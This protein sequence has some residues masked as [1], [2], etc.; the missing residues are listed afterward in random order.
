MYVYDGVPRYPG[1]TSE[2]ATLLAAW[3]GSNTDNAL[4]VTAQSGVMTVFYESV[5][6]HSSMSCVSAS[7]KRIHL[8]SVVAQ[9]MVTGSSFGNQKSWGGTD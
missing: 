2:G 6:P 9:K 4:F 8:V 5:A 3:C 1:F 7:F